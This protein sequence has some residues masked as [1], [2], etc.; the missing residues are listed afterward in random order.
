MKITIAFV[1]ESGYNKK[2]RAQVRKVKEAIK[3]LSDKYKGKSGQ[4]AQK[5]TRKIKDLENML[6]KLRKAAGFKGASKPTPSLKKS[7][8]TKPTTTK[9][10]KAPQASPQASDSETV[11]K[12][13]DNLL[14]S[15]E[16]STK[17]YRGRDK[18][19]LN[20]AQN[21]LVEQLKQ[22]LGRHYYEAQESDDYDPSVS[23]KA[24]ADYG[25]LDKLDK[26]TESD[27]DT[28]TSYAY[29]QIN[30][31]LKKQQGLARSIKRAVMTKPAPEE[32]A[33]KGLL[34]APSA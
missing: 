10:A 25:R 12:E 27:W 13:V 29:E 6:N 5:A 8:D 21:K 22:N 7:V 1:E 18:A 30:K 3:N 32:M 20:P 14:S 19:T 31:L 9:K 17:G 16:K 15:L 24:L 34:K 33:N 4:R 28:K 26:Y 23:E 11:N 2:Q